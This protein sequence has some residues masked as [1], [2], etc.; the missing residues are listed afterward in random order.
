MSFYSDLNNKINKIVELYLHKEI[1]NKKHFLDNVKVSQSPEDKFGDI[2]TNVALIIANVLKKNPRNFALELVK[3]I[4]KIDNVDD[5]KVEGPGFINFTLNKNFWLEEIKKVLI[6][7][8]KYGL[9]NIGKNTPVNIEFVSANPTGPLHVGHCRGAVYGDVLANLLNKVGYKVTKEFYVNDSGNQIDKLTKSVLFR[10]QECLKNKKTK[11][12]PQNIYPGEYLIPIGRELKKNY[13][14]KLENGNKKNLELIKSFSIDKIMKEIKNDLDLLGVHFDH[15]VSENS[16]LRVKKVNTAFEYLKKNN[17]IYQGILKK[18]KGKEI[19]DWEPRKQDLFKST[20]FGDDIDRPIKKSNGDYT[21]FAKDIAYHFDKF[22]RGFKYMINVWGA[23]HGGYIKRLTSAVNAITQNKVKLVIKICQLVKVIE[24][25][26]IL[27]MSKREGNFI[28]LNEVIKKV[29]KDVI[30]FIMLT[31]KNNEKL[32]FDLKKATQE[33]KENSV[34]YVQY[35]HAR[36]CS[37]LREASKHLKSNEISIDKIKDESI[38]LINDNFELKLIKDIVKW[39]KI[40]EESVL[41]QEPHR[42]SFYLQ[43]LSSKFHSLWNYGKKNAQLRFINLNDKNLT[44]ARL[45]MIYALK[46]ILNNGLNLLGV[47]PLEVMK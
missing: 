19:D 2:S 14:S 1:K 12:I 22:Q 28:S 25:K 17:L 7:K 13:S 32:E 20:K 21:Y 46:I 16:L 44:I 11:N 26:K 38:D 23:D 31:R 24:N 41:Y 35:A 3:K 15:F 36:C 8:D 42:I 40:I 10:Y 39:P 5:V 37:V 34:F 47:K 18:P 30:R 9:S 4:K 29:G 33:S 45:R 27:K 43:S 6:L